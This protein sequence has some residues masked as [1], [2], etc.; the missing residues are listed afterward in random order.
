MNNVHGMQLTESQSRP[1]A[2]REP[3]L[4]SVDS[5][6]PGLPGRQEEQFYPEHCWLAGA[7]VWL[8]WGPHSEILLASRAVVSSCKLLQPSPKGP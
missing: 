3:G 6:E 4:G 8:K 1:A 2:A 7:L 5:Y